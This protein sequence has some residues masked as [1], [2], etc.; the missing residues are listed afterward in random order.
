MIKAN[1]RIRVQRNLSESLQTSR[2]AEELV[3]I[4]IWSRNQIEEVE[5]VRLVLKPEHFVTEIWRE[6]YRAMLDIVAAGKQPDAHF[7]A[8][9]VADVLSMDVAAVAAEFIRATEEFTGY[10]V[11]CLEF[12]QSVVR[13]W[14]EHELIKLSLRIVESVKSAQSAT[15]DVIN[16]AIKE[17]NEIRE[18]LIEISHEEFNMAQAV[19]DLMSRTES[20]VMS[21]GIGVLDGGL[22]GG[23]REQQLIVVGARPSNGKSSL[24]GQMAIAIAGRGTPVLYLA[25]EMTSDEMTLRWMKQAGMDASDTL[26]VEIFS[27]LPMKM[28]EV[29][30]WSISRLELEAQQSVRES[31]MKVLFLDQLG[32]L[33]GSDARQS[34]REQMVEN[35]SKLKQLAGKLK[36]TVVVAHQFSRGNEMRETHRPKMSDFKDSGSVEEDADV[37]IGLHRDKTPGQGNKST[38]YIMKNRAG[39]TVDMEMD[40]DGP[41]TMFLD[42]SSGLPAFDGEEF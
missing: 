13:R 4:A 12:A 42:P 6:S 3:V 24:L 37:L 26:D 7:V 38:V 10:S 29:A 18:G 17:L 2:T 28:K 15:T 1:D 34:K 21:T 40:Y 41:R 23:L 36:I 22:K 9:V 20:Q 8:P 33:S 31:G 19:A 30:G 27:Q 32:P 5:Q 25:N 11:S 14:Q 35:T 39:E 16:Q